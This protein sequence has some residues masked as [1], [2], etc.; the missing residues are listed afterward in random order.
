[1]H[2]LVSWKLLMASAA[3][4]RNS[5][6]RKH[7]IRTPAMSLEKSASRQCDQ[8][9]HAVQAVSKSDKSVSK[10]MLSLSRNPLFVMESADPTRSF[11]GGMEFHNQVNII[12]NTCWLQIRGAHFHGH[13][14]QLCQTRK[15]YNLSWRVLSSHTMFTGHWVNTCLREAW[16]IV[17][18]TE[19]IK[20]VVESAEFP[21]CL[22]IVWISKH[23]REDSPAHTRHPGPPRRIYIV[24]Q[25][26]GITDPQ[27]LLLRCLLCLV[28]EEVVQVS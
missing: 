6:I 2:L 11:T 19:N 28:C 24:F 20:Y 21:L 1:M 7:G 16:T 15:T 18:N 17:S 10:S 14:P 3:S 23:V 12:W 25:L 8:I 13:A 4:L 5:T 27:N 22:Q 9:L 26:E